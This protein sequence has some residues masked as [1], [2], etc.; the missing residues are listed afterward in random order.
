MET[1][2]TYTDI[3]KLF[4]RVVNKYRSLEKAPILFGTG[5]SLFRQEVSAI[6]AIGADP[7][8]NVSELAHILGVTK[9]TASPIVTRLAKR[10]LVNKYKN[11]DNNKEVLLELTVRGESV[12]HENELLLIKLRQALFERY[13]KENPEY[14]EFLKDFL[15]QMEELIEEHYAELRS[16]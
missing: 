11:L 5:D 7:G 12:Y 1:R 6:Q 14:L 4:R 9:G 3:L 8:R 10:G 16:Q 13:E 15:V 2:S